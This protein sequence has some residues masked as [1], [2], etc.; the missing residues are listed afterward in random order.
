MNLLPGSQRITADSQIGS[1]TKQVRLFSVSLVSGAT[2]STLLLK[3]GTSTSGTAYEQVDGFANQSVTK[4]YNGGLLFPLTSANAGG[5]F[6]DV[7]ANI[8][9]ATFVFTEEL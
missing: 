4:N 5:L 3:N 1:G 6:A 8:S 9:Y 7:D 2:N